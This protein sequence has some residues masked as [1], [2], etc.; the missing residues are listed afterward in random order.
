MSQLL[1]SSIYERVREKKENYRRYNFERLQEEAFATFFDLAQEYTTIDY[2]YQISVAVP[3]EFF[4]L[5][6][7]LYVIDPKTSRLERVCSSETGLVSVEDR[8]HYDLRVADASY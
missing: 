4:G 7:Q 3:K 1:M 8:S 5:E 2:L 6:S